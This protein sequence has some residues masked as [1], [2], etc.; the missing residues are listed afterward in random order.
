MAAKTKISITLCCLLVAA[1]AIDA[2]RE[3][4]RQA[5]VVVMLGIIDSWQALTRHARPGGCRYT[6]TCSV[7]GELVVHRYGAYRGSWL[8]AKRIWRCSP[9][10]GEG[11]DWPE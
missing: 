8:A 10:G 6:P 5:G 4:S 3:P 2:Q 11:E 9:W 1:A 7:Y